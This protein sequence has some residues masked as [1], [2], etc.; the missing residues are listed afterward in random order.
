MTTASRPK[1]MI[2]VYRPDSVELRAEA[3]FAANTLRD[4]DFDLVLKF[5]GKNLTFHIHG[6]ADGEWTETPAKQPT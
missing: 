4:A 5:E 6:N 2:G 3:G 1:E